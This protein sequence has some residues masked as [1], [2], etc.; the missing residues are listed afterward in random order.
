M[1]GSDDDGTGVDWQSQKPLT[2]MGKDPTN[3]LAKCEGDC[4]SNKDCWKPLMCFY[5]GKADP[6]A[7]VPGCSGKGKPAADYCYDPADE[8]GLKGG[9]ASTKGGG[10]K[11]AN[12]TRAPTAD[13]RGREGK[14]GALQP[15][16]WIGKDPTRTLIKCEGDCDS[17]KDC[18]RP[19]KC[20]FR[21]KADPY[22][23]V[24]GCFGRGRAQADYCYH[25]GE[26]VLVGKIDVVLGGGKGAGNVGN[27]ELSK[28]I[29]GGGNGEGTGGYKAAEPAPQGALVA[30]GPPGGPFQGHRLAITQVPYSCDDED[31]DVGG[32]AAEKV[33]QSM[34]RVEPVGP[35]FIFAN[36]AWGG[37]HVT[38]TSFDDYRDPIAKFESL[39][40][41]FGPAYD[42]NWLPLNI[43]R[44]KKE[45]NG[46][47]TTRLDFDSELL[48]DLALKLDS[49]GFKGKHGTHRHISIEEGMDNEWM[50]SNVL[51]QDT[52]WNVV[53]LTVHPDYI[54]KRASM[55]M[56]QTRLHTRS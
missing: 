15:L 23:P 24:P 51:R 25:P 42:Q 36:P 10:G 30:P 21:G 38:M 46:E 50:I 9:K 34:V 20:F 56:K 6:Y 13:E 2:W 31:C 33:G 52:N 22:A 48:E 44:K 18:Y 29:K 16:T 28:G 43:T 5:R 45:C 39:R 32:C 54:E 26:A 27:K 37:L 11:K 47:K 41:L 1:D 4:D 17:D 55:M 49:A 40:Q 12:A 53:L 19:L 8:R 3:K 35:R 7:A 14:F